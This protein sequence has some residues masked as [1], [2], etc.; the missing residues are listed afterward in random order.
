MFLSLALD[1]SG[2]WAQ[3][4]VGKYRGKTKS[5]PPSSLPYCTQDNLATLKAVAMRH[6][7]L[8]GADN[9]HYGLWKQELATSDLHILLER[10]VVA[11]A[12]ASTDTA[13]AR[14]DKEAVRDQAERVFKK[15]ADDHKTV[16][17]QF[18]TAEYGG[19]R[20]SQLAGGCDWVPVP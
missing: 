4:Q 11:S 14:Y 7:G 13:Q 20:I 5:P 3:G 12:T 9:S 18:D 1:D 15:W 17:A 2:S 16:Q 10:I 6:E 8:T 19:N